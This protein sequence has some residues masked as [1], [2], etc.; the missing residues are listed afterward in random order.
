MVTFCQNVAIEKN[1]SDIACDNL[2][3]I[4]MSIIHYDI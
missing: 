3:N 4:A 2:T 1:V